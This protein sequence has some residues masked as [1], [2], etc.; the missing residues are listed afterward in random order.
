MAMLLLRANISALKFLLRLLV[1]TD[2][3]L[4]NKRRTSFFKNLVYLLKSIVILYRT[5]IQSRRMIDMF[6]PKKPL[7][8]RLYYFFYTLLIP[9]LF[10]LQLFML[11]RTALKVKDSKKWEKLIKR[12]LIPSTNVN[13]SK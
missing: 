2:V 3:Y 13:I 11:F 8:V 7:K 9:I 4:L 6:Y 10:Y 12:R 1:V 5:F